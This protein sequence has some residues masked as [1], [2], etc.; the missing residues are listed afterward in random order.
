MLSQCNLVDVPSGGLSSFAVILMTFYICQNYG[1]HLGTDAGELLK[2][3]SPLHLTPHCTTSHSLLEAHSLLTTFCTTTTTLPSPSQQEFLHVYGEVFDFAQ[4]SVRVNPEGAGYGLIAKVHPSVA[5]SICDPLDANNNV[6]DQCNRLTH[7]RSMFR[8][9]YMA[10]GK[11]EPASSEAFRGR[12]PLSTIIA[13][14]AL[15]SRLS[16][17][18]QEQ[19]EAQAPPVRP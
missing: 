18:Q 2:V 6:A 15:W 9:C 8:Y 5:I 11:W 10:L 14:N 7:I 16:K 13:H 3:R 19:G 17:F 12:T 1:E 4:C